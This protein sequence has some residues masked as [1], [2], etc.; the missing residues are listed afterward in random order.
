MK[1]LFAMK[2]L[3]S[4]D[5]N[6]AIVYG[7]SEVLVR[8][9]VEVHVLGEAS[10]DQEHHAVSVGIR[11]HSLHLKRHVQPDRACLAIERM[12]KDLS[13]ARKALELMKAPSSAM[14]LVLERL[15]PFRNTIRYA[16]AYRKRIR[17]LHSKHRFN[18]V[19][20]VSGPFHVP[21]G[22]AQTKMQT[23]KVYYQLDPFCSLPANR[24]KRGTLAL[25][26]YVCQRADHLFMNGLIYQDYTSSPLAGYLKKSDI[27]EL[28]C[29]RP[30]NDHPEGTKVI[31]DPRYM[32]FLFAGRL[33]SD[34]RSPGYFLDLISRCHERGMA[35]RAYFLGP[36][37]RTNEAVLLRHR[38]ELREDLILLDQVGRDVAN[39]VML[40]SDILVNIGNSVPNLF[41]SKM[42]DYF[43]TGKPVVNIHKLENCPTLQYASKYP[44]CISICEAEEITDSLVS[45]FIDFCLQN[46]HQRLTYKSIERI[47]PENTAESVGQRI[48]RMMTETMYENGS[49]SGCRKI[50]CG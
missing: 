27:L 46:R 8:D 33:Y 48:Y 28:P 16:R 6:S 44:L 45:R 17:E 41:P 4:A 37:A 38:L 34:I 47:F 39:A 50:L 23:R 31:F 12:S 32:N 29:I 19:I 13:K 14:D 2:T 25:E 7:L 5:P 26:R 15:L 35:S 18:L 21:L 36:L 20:G 49:L 11:V 9:R 42:L 1:V 30:M 3:S 10:A 22:M 43:S 24:N 40:G